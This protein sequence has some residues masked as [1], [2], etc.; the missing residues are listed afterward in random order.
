MTDDPIS[1]AVEQMRYWRDGRHM[2]PA[3]MLQALGFRPS[4]L[5]ERPSFDDAVWA[6]ARLYIETPAYLGEAIGAPDEVCGWS[7]EFKFWGK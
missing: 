3:E 6:L 1:V 5:P 7:L 4:E 2:T